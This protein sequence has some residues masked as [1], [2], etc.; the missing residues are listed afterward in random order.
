M[1]I[2]VVIHRIVQIAGSKDDLDNSYPSLHHFREAAN[3]RT[4]FKGT[5][6]ELTTCLQS[7][8]EHCPGNE[9]SQV[10]K[11]KRESAER[12]TRSEKRE[13]VSLGATPMLGFTP[14]KRRCGGL[15][16][17]VVLEPTKLDKAFAVSSKVVGCEVINERQERCSGYPMFRVTNEGKTKG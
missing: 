17:D 12:R 4:S 8:I 13:L 3:Q 16:Q 11:T 1:M 7:I 5:L 9:S 6:F 10:A 2:A 15:A 14:R